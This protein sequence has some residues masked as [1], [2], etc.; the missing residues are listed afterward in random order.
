MRPEVTLTLYDEAGHAHSVPV[1]ARR[2]T[3]GRLPA[4][5]LVIEDANLSLRHAVI[6]CVDG[7]VLISDCGSEHGTLVNGVPVRAGVEL[8]DGD[9]ITLGGDSEMTVQVRA[10][11]DRPATAS[12]A[13]D[14]AAPVAGGAR[15][16]EGAS[17][18]QTAAKIE[19]RSYLFAA[20]PA[21][22]VLLAVVLLISISKLT[23]EDSGGDAAERGRASLGNDGATGRQFGEVSAPASERPEDAGANGAATEEIERYALR[24]L[25]DISDDPNPTLA[26]EAVREIQMRIEGYR[27]SAALRNNLRRLGRAELQQLGPAARQHNLKLPL[28]ALAALAKADRDGRGDP[29]VVAREML[30][31]LAH[32]RGI[33]GTEL[34]NDSLLVVAASDGGRGTTTHPLQ[35][36]IFELTKRQPDSP[37]AIRNVWYLRAH[38]R[39]SPRAYDLVLRFLAI[40]VIAHNPRSYGVDA[41][42]LAF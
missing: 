31:A 23:G 11:A 37:A 27:D 9:V 21:G 17:C 15:T 39:L 34:A 13:N 33:F 41:A 24:V 3:I 19:R 40:G 38:D 2:F 7:A 4:N 16:V 29:V 28:L 8:H 6:E 10:A 5:D 1:E 22:L 14:D 32:L 35:T 36:A 30:P 20:A 26:R 12:A 25:R 42:P 18:D